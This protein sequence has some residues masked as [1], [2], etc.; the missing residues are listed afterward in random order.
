MSKPYTHIL[1]FGAEAGNQV[2]TLY[3]HDDGM[4]LA[5]IRNKSVMFGSEPRMPQGTRLFIDHDHART[6]IRRLADA[7]V[8][9]FMKEERDPGWDTWKWE[10]LPLAQFTHSASIEERDRDKMVRL[11]GIREVQKIL[12]N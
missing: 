12:S 9:G 2:A 4:V 6:Y 3:R 10:T 5:E 8:S 1:L 11:P 7:D